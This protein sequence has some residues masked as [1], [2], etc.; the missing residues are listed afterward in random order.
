MLFI[1]LFVE[2]LLPLLAETCLARFPS[3]PVYKYTRCSDDLVGAVNV[4]AAFAR[5]WTVK[6]IKT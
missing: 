2:Y 3:R 1:S 6:N 4:L 5:G